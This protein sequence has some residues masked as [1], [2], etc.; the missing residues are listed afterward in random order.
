MR[1]F[2]SIAMAAGFSL[3]LMA[4]TAPDVEFVGG[5][6]K[7]IPLNTFG[8]LDAAT[9]SG[10]HFRYGKSDFDVPYSRIVRTEVGETPGAHLWK[11]PMPHLGKSTRLLTVTYKEGESGTGMVTFRASTSTISAINSEIDD[12]RKAPSAAAA[13]TKGVDKKATGEEWWGDTYWR[14]NRNKAKWPNGQTA[15]AQQSGGGSK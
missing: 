13:S 12:Q 1:L 3:A 7:L 2:A 8:T 15:D 4:A 10:L 6:T 14:T 9:A 5:T 11:V